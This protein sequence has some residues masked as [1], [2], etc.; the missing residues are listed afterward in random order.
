MA[1]RIRASHIL[2]EKF[3]EAQEVLER[4][5]KGEDFAKVAMEKSLDGSRRRGG[6]LGYFGR[7][8]MVKPF[9]QAAFA[10]EKGQLSDIVKTEFGYHIIKR[11]D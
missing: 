1:A 9:E 10:L 6:D 5:K 11:T 7:G 8:V 4:L 2:V 3:T